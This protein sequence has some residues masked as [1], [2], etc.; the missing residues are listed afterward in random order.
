MRKFPFPWPIVFG[1][2]FLCAAGAAQALGFG[3]VVN[4]SHLGQP[5]NFAATVRLDPDESL[6]RECVSAEVLSGEQRVPSVAVRVTLE[7]AAEPTERMV[8]V[9]T[10]TQIDEPVVTVSIS[11]GC[12]GRITR[13][14]VTLVDPPGVFLAQA[15][16]AA[17]VTLPPQRTESQV[18]P[19][20]AVVQAV[21]AASAARP[22]APTSAPTEPRPPAEPP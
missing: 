16:S 3:R 5:L 13:A 18:A 22:P 15:G 10:S 20:V 8:R 6:L 17:P 7:P 9:T 4:A 21:N 2:A 14:F 11:A 1:C 19:V 12:N